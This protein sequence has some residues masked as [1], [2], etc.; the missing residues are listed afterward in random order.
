MKGSTSHAMAQRILRKQRLVQNAAAERADM[1]RVVTQT[2]QAAAFSKGGVAGFAWGLLRRT[3]WLA[4]VLAALPQLRR[5]VPRYALVGTGS[6]LMVWQA[7]DWLK[8]KVGKS[9][10]A[11]AGPALPPD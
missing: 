10:D 7:Y 5:P 11:A 8:K 3:P 1:V 2:R 6:A 9:P 4:P